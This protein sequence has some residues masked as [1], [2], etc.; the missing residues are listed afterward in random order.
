MKSHEDPT[1]NGVSVAVIKPVVGIDSNQLARDA[2]LIS[3][4]NPGWEEHVLVYRHKVAKQI[5]IA[6]GGPKRIR[7][8]CNPQKTPP[9]AITR[10]VQSIE[11]DYFFVNHS[12][13]LDVDSSKLEKTYS[14]LL[15]TSHHGIH[16]LPVHSSS[17]YAQKQQEPDKC[18][19]ESLLH[20]L[21]MPF[22]GRGYAL[23]IDPELF[24]YMGGFHGNLIEHSEIDFLLRCIEST[25]VT[26][27]VWMDSPLIRLATPETIAM[28]SHAEGFNI[29]CAQSEILAKRLEANRWSHRI[30]R[31]YL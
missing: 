17:A 26:F 1:F 2:T 30:E 8:H 19:F 14:K 20:R 6:N 31:V 16:F 3:K 10:L 4:L 13:N 18:F 12:D 7:L 22:D 23:L 5:A 25:D 11:A 24:R 15:A 9:E 27:G 21:A 29:E 28:Q